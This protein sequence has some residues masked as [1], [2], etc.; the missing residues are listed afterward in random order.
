MANELSFSY[1]T[2]Q[3]IKALVWG[4]NR[5]TRWN[6]SA[7]VAP[8]TIADAD[9]ATGM[10]TMT[11]QAT[12]DSTATGQYVGSLPFTGITGEHQVDYLLGASPTPGQERIGYQAADTQDIGGLGAE[13]NANEAK[14]DA[15]GTVVTA[16][17]PAQIS[18]LETHGDSTWATATGFATSS[19][20]AAA[21]TKIDTIDGVV[22][23]IRV[24][25]GTTLPASISSVG[26]ASAA[27]IWALAGAIDGKTPA[28]AMQIIAAAAAGKVS[29]AGTGTEVF[30]GLGG[31][32]T[33]ITVTVDDDGNR[34]EVT[35]G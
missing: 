5:T 27:E 1:L 33:R 34:S 19:A 24:D 7:M 20:L 3:T 2:G 35:Y 23:A 25:T 15:I 26:G 9:W 22:D 13:I 31:D 4:K 28:Q 10:V 30:K 16:T 14:I 6:G 8:S 32:T 12:S 11:E 21:V 18:A 29:G 17:I